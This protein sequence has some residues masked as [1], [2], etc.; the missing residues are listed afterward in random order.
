MSKTKE[1]PPMDIRGATIKLMNTHRFLG[2]LINEGLRWHKHISYTIGKGTAYV[3]QLCHLSL[4]SKEIPPALSRKLYT[5]VPLPKMLYT[6]DLWFKPIYTRELDVINKG[7]LGT[8]KRMG[9]VQ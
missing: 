6:L 4:Y 5:S 9:R 7:S 2:V 8:A 3:L 1:R